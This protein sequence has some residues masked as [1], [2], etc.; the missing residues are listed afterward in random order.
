M[1]EN[2]YAPPR[3]EVA[4]SAPASPAKPSVAARFAWTAGCTFVVFMIL[5]L[6]ITPA[7]WRLGGVGSLAFALF[8]GLI[9]MCIPVRAKVGFII[10]GMVVAL[11]IAYL[12]GSRAH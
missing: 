3:T 4:D 10:P 6:L 5:I 8:A 12:I 7:A 9:G 11:L 1:S 2:P